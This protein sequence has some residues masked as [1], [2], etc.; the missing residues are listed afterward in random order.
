LLVRDR[1]TW[2]ELLAALAVLS[3]VG[4]LVYGRHVVRGGLYS[5]D[6]AIASLTEHGDGLLSEYRDLRT[7]VGFRPLGVALIIARFA[8]LNDHAH[9]HL[10]VA[11]GLTV[12]LCAA[13]YLLLRMLRFEPIH[14][15]AIALL[16]LACPYADASRLWATGSGANIAIVLWILGVAVGLRGFAAK[17]RRGAITLHACAVS[18]Y[19]ASLMQGEIAYFAICASGL[20]YLTR[21]EIRRV[22]PRS[23]VDVITATGV[24][25][26]IASKSAIPR[27]ESSYLHHAR[28]MFDGGIE[29]LAAVAFP[30]GDLRA[31]TVI[32]LLSLV[33]AVAATAVL[34]FPHCEAVRNDLVRWLALGAGGLVLAVAGYAPFVGASEWYQP[35]SPGLGNRTNA[36]SIIG[37]VATAY[38]GVATGGTLFLR[39]VSRSRAL[40]SG[41]AV[42]IATVLFIGYYNRLRESAAVWDRTWDQEKAI[43]TTL[44]RSLPNPPP[45]STIY[46]FGHPLL[47][48][49]AG[50]PIFYQSWELRG[51]VQTVFDDPSI[52]AYPALPGTTVACTADGAHFEGGGYISSAG[53]VYGDV[54]LVDIPSGR[55]ERIESRSECVALAPQF[56]AGPLQVSRPA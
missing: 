20:L 32:L 30:F 17:T 4:V 41:L 50:L 13:I 54:F 42:V 33:F 49:N 55:V 25:A 53:D 10:A 7:Q 38:A 51:A 29:I 52:A 21:A 22:V 37:F 8:L 26:V 44:Q 9:Q 14:A 19:V 18:L 3:G 48:E 27:T 45:S 24:V 12:L 40:A 46:T 6:W 34:L 5:D 56:K 43:L 47:S 16:V 36:V 28:L 23:A 15:G 1:L 31:A 35:L 2:R 11:L 39:A